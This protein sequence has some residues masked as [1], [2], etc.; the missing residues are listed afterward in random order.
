ML[1]HDL[2]LEHKDAWSINATAEL[3]F[4]HQRWALGVFLVVAAAFVCLAPMPEM[5]ITF[6][7]GDKTFHMVG[8]GALSLYFA[9]LMPRNQ[10]WKIF[11]FLLVFGVAVW[12]SR[13]HSRRRAEASRGVTPSGS[14]APTP[15][16]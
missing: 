4:L 5:P 10:W 1:L 11:S 15:I 3:K 12:S 16:R 6:D 13:T 8:H 7:W 9:G 2:L 14:A